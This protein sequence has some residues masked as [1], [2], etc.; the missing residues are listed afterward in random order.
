MFMEVPLWPQ[1]ALLVVAGCAS[2]CVLCAYM[3]TIVSLCVYVCTYTSGIHAVL[4]TGWTCKW[5]RQQTDWRRNHL[6]W[7]V[8]WIRVA[9]TELISGSPLLPLNNCGL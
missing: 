4:A 2:Q 1:L 9:I 8:H 6:G 3:C 7:K 5:E